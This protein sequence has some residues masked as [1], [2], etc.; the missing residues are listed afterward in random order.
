MS[1]ECLV[2]RDGVRLMLHDIS[3]ELQL[4][5]HTTKDAE[6]DCMYACRNTSIASYM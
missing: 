6:K 1:G 3:G 5:I 4:I 2:Y